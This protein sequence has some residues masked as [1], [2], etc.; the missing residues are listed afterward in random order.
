MKNLHFLGIC[1]TAMGAFASALARQGYHV[2]GSDAHAYDPMKSFLEREGVTLFE[3]YRAENIPADTELVIIGNAM[4][5][6]NAEV[7]ATLERRLRY[8]SLPEAIKEFFLW[9]RHNYVVSGT[10]GKTTTTTLL[11]WLLESSGRKP[12]FLIGGIARNFERGSRFAD[13]DYTVLEGD[14]YDTAFFDKRSKFNHYLPE[15]VIVNNIEMDHAD[16]FADVEAIRKSF[17]YMLRLVPSTGRVF[18]NADCENCRIVR[19]NAPAEIPIR[20]VGQSQD[21]DIRIEDVSYAETSSS[22]TLEGQRYTVPMTGEF[23]VYNAAMATCAALFAGLS[24]EQINAGFAGF[25]GIARRQELRGTERGVHVIDDF[26]HHPTAIGLAIRALRQRY[27]EGRIIGIFDPRSNTSGSNLFQDEL[28]EALALADYAVIAPVERAHKFCEKTILDM[29]QLQR[30]VSGAETPC[31]TARS[32]DDIV[33]H[34]V[35]RA[36][37][38]DVLL[39]M[40]NGGFGGIHKKLLHALK[41]S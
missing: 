32:I 2:T 25:L 40:S 5:R 34:I 15:V 24:P 9:G 23:N 30:D 38:G 18:L 27:P 19:A 31:Y 1:G 29:E 28:A 41:E 37:S 3:G 21:A 35:P 22:F 12:N 14:E 33:E 6:G 16:I 39:V 7:E 13:S 8:M 4:S 26:A 20:L 10:H 17:C 11:T 36:Q